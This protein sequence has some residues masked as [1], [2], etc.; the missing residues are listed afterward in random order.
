MT[1]S[2]LLEPASPIPLSSSAQWLESVLLGQ[3]AVSLCMIA[4]AVVGFV[5]L[6]GRL[7]V[8]RGIWTV[9]GC[10]VLIGAPVIAGAFLNS[11]ESNV[12]ARFAGPATEWPNFEA[13]RELPPP[14]NDPY[15]GASLRRD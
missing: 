12:A 4:V 9:L 1:Q 10:F 15:A 7:P 3:V 13:R 2:S 8:R 5:M 6:S 14:Q 11:E